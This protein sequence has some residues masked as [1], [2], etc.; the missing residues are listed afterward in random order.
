[1]RHFNFDVSEFGGDITMTGVLFEPN[2][3]ISNGAV[4]PIARS[5]CPPVHSC[6]VHF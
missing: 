5:P 4:G 6:R 1:M 3:L 2:W